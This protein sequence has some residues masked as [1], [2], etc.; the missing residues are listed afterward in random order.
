MNNSVHTNV[1]LIP[2]HRNTLQDSHHFYI[3]YFRDDN[4]SPKKKARKTDNNTSN[5]TVIILSNLC[6][7]T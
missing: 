3:S 5:N 7:Y 6:T 4:I 1:G 2:V